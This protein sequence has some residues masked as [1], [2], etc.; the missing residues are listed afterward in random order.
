MT[1]ISTLG[2][3]KAIHTSSRSL[4][5]LVVDDAAAKRHTLGTYQNMIGDL[6]G[7]APPSRAT[8]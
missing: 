5:L 7:T 6:D 4:H 3:D 8:S 1:H 2:L